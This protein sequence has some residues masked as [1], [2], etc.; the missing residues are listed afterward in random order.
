M[1]AHATEA[2]RRAP[3]SARPARPCRTRCPVPGVLCFV[4]SDWALLGR[5]FTIR[6]VHAPW[7]RKP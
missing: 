5:N 7:L 4:D 1:S 3:Q 6:E 2:R